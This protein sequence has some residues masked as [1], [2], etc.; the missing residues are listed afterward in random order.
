MTKV[1]V[2][3]AGGQIARWAITMLAAENAELTLF[4]RDGHHAPHRRHDPG[5]HTGMRH[6]TRL[7]VTS[8]RTAGMTTSLSYPQQTPEAAASS[9]PVTCGPPQH[10]VPCPA[11][12]SSS[13]AWTASQR[14][15]P[16]WPQKVEL[17]ARTV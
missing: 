9:W 5:M 16:S 14:C 12:A 3:G 1:L 15:S 4:L 11:G 13:S 10:W 2:L 8:P 17:S 6:P 7:L